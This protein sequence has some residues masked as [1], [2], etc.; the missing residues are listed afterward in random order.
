MTDGKNDRYPQRQ[1]ESKST[2]VK[3][4]SKFQVKDK[5]QILSRILPFTELI[6]LSMHRLCQ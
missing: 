3:S 2:S 4:F 5:T 1:S 6:N